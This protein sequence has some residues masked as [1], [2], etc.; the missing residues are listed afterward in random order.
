MLTEPSADRGTVFYPYSK[1]DVRKKGEKVTSAIIVR[2]RDFLSPEAKKKSV[3]SA[4]PGAQAKAGGMEYE[5]DEE[6]CQAIMME[7][8]FQV[9][10]AFRRFDESGM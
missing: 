7:L 1:E 10:P 3:S 6:L 2:A 8:Q 5:V 9:E 4:S